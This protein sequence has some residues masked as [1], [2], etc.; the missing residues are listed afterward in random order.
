MSKRQIALTVTFVARYV[1][2][3]EELQE[4]TEELDAEES[5]ALVI[6]E[7]DPKNVVLPKVLE[8]VTIAVIE[9]HQ[10]NINK[11]YRE[12][13]ERERA[14]RE[15]EKMLFEMPANNGQRA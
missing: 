7:L 5:I 2:E 6:P 12:K 8:G 9:A 10:R 11:F 14:A 1:G 4:V 3:D 13:A 15:R